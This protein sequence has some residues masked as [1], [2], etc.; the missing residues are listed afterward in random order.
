MDDDRPAVRACERVGC[1]A[2]LIEQGGDFVVPQVMI[3]FDGAFAAH[4]DC[5]FFAQFFDVDRAVIKDLLNDV[6]NDR[7]FFPFRK[8]CRVASDDIAAGAERFEKDAD[9]G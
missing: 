9:F 6:F 7:R 4:H 5:G 3:G 1:S 2:Q 8:P